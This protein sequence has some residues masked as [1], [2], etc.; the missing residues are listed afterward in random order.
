[1]TLEDDAW[2][3]EELPF[4]ITGRLSSCSMVGCSRIGVVGADVDCCWSFSRSLTLAV[5]SAHVCNQALWSCSVFPPKRGGRASI[6]TWVTNCG[7]EQVKTRSRSFSRTKSLR[8][9]KGALNHNGAVTIRTVVAMAWC[10]SIHSSSCWAI[11]PKW[12]QPLF[13]SYIHWSSTALLIHAGVHHKPII[14]EHSKQ[15]TSTNTFNPLV[16]QT[17]TSWC[18]LHAFCFNWFMHLPAICNICA[19]AFITVAE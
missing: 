17:K 1:M 8:T 16:H 15:L 10:K 2:T 11:P 12:P 14:R 5:T 7:V 9:L 3:V 4:V 19:K 18:I 6:G 13:Q